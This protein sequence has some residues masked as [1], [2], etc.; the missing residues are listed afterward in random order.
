MRNCNLTWGTL[1]Q[2]LPLL[3]EKGLIKVEESGRQKLYLATPL[4][5]DVAEATWLKT[6]RFPTETDRYEIQYGALGILN[7]EALF[8]S[9][10]LMSMMGMS[11]LFF[12]SR[13]WSLTWNFRDGDLLQYSSTST[14]LGRYR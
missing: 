10:G 3:Q 2:E 1:V 11:F 8:L 14:S 6:S 12:S 4:G 7:D 5:M 13:T 9:A